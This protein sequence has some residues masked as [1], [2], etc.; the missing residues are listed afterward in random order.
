MITPDTNHE[1]TTAVPTIQK[2]PPAYSP[3]VD[4]DNPIGMNAAVVMSAPVSRGIAVDA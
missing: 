1:N 2:M 4:L 3:V